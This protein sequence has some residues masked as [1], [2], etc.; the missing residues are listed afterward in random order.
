MR[1]DVVPPYAG[2]MS[3]CNAGAYI[4]ID[5]LL[6]SPSAE[7]CWTPPLGMH[8]RCSYAADGIIMDCYFSTDIKLQ[9]QCI[10][11]TFI[12]VLQLACTG[13]STHSKSLQGPRTRPVWAC[14]LRGT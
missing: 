8:T 13:V 2:S 4:I 5:G 1:C 3:E 12:L 14:L 9:A 6:A 10:V 7:M 11:L